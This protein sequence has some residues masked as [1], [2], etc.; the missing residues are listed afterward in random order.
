[1]KVKQK[2]L[3]AACILASSVTL[4]ASLVAPTSAESCGGV[5]TSIIH[6]DQKG[7]EGVSAKESGAWGL[8]LSILNI[9]T[10][11]V[12]ILAVGGIVYASILYASASDSADQTKKAKEVIRNVAIGILAYAGMYLGLNFLIP[13]GIFN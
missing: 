13:G 8:L 11:G 4:S 7:G 12:G 1:M 3:M 9:M 2:V 6:C 5:E 10:A